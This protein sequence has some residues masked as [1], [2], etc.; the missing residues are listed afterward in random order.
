M[1]IKSANLNKQDKR[2]EPAVIASSGIDP[3]S[4]GEKPKKQ[5]V[6]AVKSDFMKA[7]VNFLQYPIGTLD[8]HFKGKTF[9]YKETI[10]APAGKCDIDVS[11]EILG[12]EKFGIPGPTAVELDLAIT[13]LISD[14]YEKYKKYF[15]CYRTTYYE[16]C[17]ISGKRYCT[18]ERRIIKKDL[19]KLWSTSYLSNFA[20]KNKRQDG[21][22]QEIEF[23]SKFGFRKYDSI[24]LRGEDLPANIPNEELTDKERLT[25]KTEHIYIILS[26]VYFASLQ[27]NYTK[28]I[29]YDLT[30]LL[31]GAVTKRIHQILSLAFSTR[32]AKD[33]SGKDCVNY[34]YKEFC[35]RLPLKI[36]NKKAKAKQQLKNYLDRFIHQKYLK[37][38]VFEFE[39]QPDRWFIRFYSG[40]LAKYEIDYCAGQLVLWNH[41]FSKQKQCKLTGEQLPA[42]PELQRGEPDSYQQY[43]LEQKEF[44]EWKAKI[45]LL[46]NDEKQKLRTEAINN[47]KANK[48]I[49]TELGTLLETINIYKMRKDFL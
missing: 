12:T 2:T 36:W 5:E 47:Q 26:P 3:R 37:K 22:D 20:F 28:P 25:K 41:I 24:I 34:N 18:I 49:I 35:G 17:K 21:Q 46:T 32:M 23:P 42:S 1:K 13:K 27:N 15:G 30:K 31:S 40:T 4:D 19:V 43:E 39:S 11:W 16:I 8:K 29:C 10:P 45:D 14:R 48:Q 44:K 6:L 33:A 38:Y 7:E 9:I